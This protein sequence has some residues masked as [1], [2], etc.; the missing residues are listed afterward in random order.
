MIRKKPQSSLQ[1]AHLDKEFEKTKLP[2]LTLRAE[3]KAT[4]R[5]SMRTTNFTQTKPSK[6][7]IWTNYFLKRRRVT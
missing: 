5:K 3:K 2:S 1:I 7:S 4:L 6:L